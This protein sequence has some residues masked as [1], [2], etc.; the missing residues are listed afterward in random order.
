MEIYT[1]DFIDIARSYGEKINKSIK[2][3]GGLVDYVAGDECCNLQHDIRKKLYERLSIAFDTL[4]NQEAVADVEHAYYI[5]HEFKD[6]LF[7]IIN[8]L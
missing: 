5:Q 3:G 6:K 8:E 1:G 4:V 2:E 7:K